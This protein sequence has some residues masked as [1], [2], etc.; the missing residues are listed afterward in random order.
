MARRAARVFG[1]EAV[2]EPWA[3]NCELAGVGRLK[4]RPDRGK[5]A[6]DRLVLSI[7]RDPDARYEHE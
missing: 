1:V 6:L 3:K 5:I 4:T 7:F 2:K